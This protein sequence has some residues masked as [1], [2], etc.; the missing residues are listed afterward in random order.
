MA[1]DVPAGIVR[2]NPSSTGRPPS[3]HANDTSRKRIS[4]APGSGITDPSA[5]A[6]VPTD[7]STRAIAATGAAAPSIAQFSPP[8]AIEDTPIAACTKTTTRAVVN[9]AFAAPSAINQN[10]TTLAAST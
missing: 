2:S 6:P 10:T 9:V 5:N 1:I 4:L 7:A 3:R 8:N